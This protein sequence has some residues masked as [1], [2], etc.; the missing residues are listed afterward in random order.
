M[1]QVSMTR[2]PLIAIALMLAGT[3]LTGCSRSVEPAD[4]VLMRG[5]VVTVDETHPQA[6]AIAVNGY[7]ITAVGSNRKIGRYIGP[8]TEVIELEGRLAVPGFIE[9]H[10]HF[11]S[12][13]RAMMV[14]DLTTAANWEEIVAMVAEAAA[15]AEPGEWILGRGWHQ[16]KWDS[17]PEQTIDGV[18]LHHGL[19]AVS[20]DNPVKLTHA[21][22]HAGFVNARAL[23]KAGITAR[24]AD[25]PGGEIVRDS[26]GN[27]TGLL[28]ETAQRIVDRAQA[29]D[30]EGRPQSEV[31][32]EFRQIVELASNEAISKGVTT[33][34]DAGINFA[35]IDRIREIEAS[36]DLK[37]RLYLMVRRETNEEMDRR[38]PEYLTIPE[39]NDYIAI[40]CIK[41]QIDGALGAHGAWLLEPYLD[42]PSSVGL[43]LEPVEEITRTCEIAVKHGF[44]VATH[45][46]GD[47]G[48]R[49][50]LDIYEQVMRA[51]PSA[52]DLRWRIEH[53]QH[54]HPDDINRFLELGVIAA[55]QAI[56]CTSDG[57]WVLKKLGEER[58]E[59]GAYLWRTFIDLGVVVT[60]G[61]DVPVEPID[62]LAGFHASISRLCWDGSIF[63]PDQKMTREEALRSYTLNNAYAAFEEHLKG[64]LEPGKLADIVVLSRDI[65]TIEETEIPDTVVD[66]TII[67]GEIRYTRKDMR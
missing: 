38:L 58:A 23:Q 44:Q 6:E 16:E 26:R 3:G 51:N 4:M 54:L 25:P 65:M 20:P 37:L 27:P 50:T 1:K 11:T 60:N 45:A 49:E 53:A 9:G 28:R 47:R 18:P 59:E 5:N 52:T 19:S 67:G 17:L 22:G 40:R 32:D 12:L 30:Y 14:L 63:Y 43:L 13:G 7:S 24:T 55:M 36:G 31:E 34:H 10:G 42:L 35:D 2:Y 62:P 33:F 66:L 29:H 39:G 56:H 8:E 64:S 15:G 57:P 61:T 46:I 41:R 48:N 21:S